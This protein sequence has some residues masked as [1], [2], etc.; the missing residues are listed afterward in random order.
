MSR[1]F[2]SRVMREFVPLSPLSL[3]PWVKWRRAELVRESL[4]LRHTQVLYC[5]Y[6]RHRKALECAYSVG[7]PMAE[8]ELPIL[9]GEAVRDRLFGP[10][11]AEDCLWCEAWSSGYAFALFSDGRVVK[12]G[13]VADLRRLESELALILAKLRHEEGSNPL[14]AY[15]AGQTAKTALEN[16]FETFG[17]EIADK[18]LSFERPSLAE[19]DRVEKRLTGNQDRMPVLREA[20]KIPAIA[21]VNFLRRMAGR[22]AMAIA[23]AGLAWGGYKLWP[24]TEEPE[25]EPLPITLAEQAYERLLRSPMA[26]ESLND[27]HYAYREFVGDSVFGRYGAVQTMRWVGSRVGTRMENGGTGRALEINVRMPLENLNDRGDPIDLAENFARYGTGLG[28]NVEVKGRNDLE[29]WLDCTVFVPFRD[30]NPAGEN[31][32]AE[33]LPEPGS[34]DRLHDRNIR[35]DFGPLGEVS[36]KRV[37]SNPIFLYYPFELTLRDVEWSDK[38]LVHWLS[39]RLQGGTVILDQLLLQMSPSGTQVTGTIEFRTVWCNSCDHQ[40]TPSET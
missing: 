38:A 6:M 36:L 39:R 2:A 7:G 9:L 19:C 28:W 23:I 30:T 20:S 24:E 17:Q 37:R 25:P 26:S 12:D 15:F 29:G 31:A 5:H 1:R 8:V 34:S 3:S 22:T 18:G 11:F 35:E 40:A 32:V 27:I 14:K 10:D 33:S 4:S 13:L 21:R 16:T